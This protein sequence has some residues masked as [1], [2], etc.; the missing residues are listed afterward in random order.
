MVER[1][2]RSSTLQIV[3]AHHGADNSKVNKRGAWIKCSWEVMMG[4]T[5]GLVMDGV[6]TGSSGKLAK[7]R[8]VPG[9]NIPKPPNFDGN[10][11]R[12]IIMHPLS[13]RTLVSKF[14]D[15]FS[16]TQKHLHQ[17]FNP[18]P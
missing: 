1:S 9:S 13:A 8:Y 6:S 5:L 7:G 16:K 17:Y 10:G 15:M 3:D 2:G 11:V 12:A 18:G 14:Q 4:S